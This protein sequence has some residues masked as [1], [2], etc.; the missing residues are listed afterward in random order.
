MSW[1]VLAPAFWAGYWQRASLDAIAIIAG[2]LALI[3][4]APRLSQFRPGHWG[5]LVC[6][7]VGVVVFVILLVDVVGHVGHKVGPALKA[8]ERMGPR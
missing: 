1:V 5:T 6:L 4:V 7:T 8:L 2:L 3:C